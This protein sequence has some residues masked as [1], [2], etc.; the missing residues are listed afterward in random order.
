MDKVYQ[1]SIS[2]KANEML[3]DHA[4]FISGVSETAALRLVKEFREG[5]ESLVRFP[6]RCPWLWDDLLPKHKY[7]KLI[8][9][10]K[11]LALFQVV[12]DWV[13]IE[14]LV[15]CRQNYSWLIA[16]DKK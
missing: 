8:F 6:E 15:D 11:H 4:A 10:E 16:G 7:R 9:S 2:P 12:D 14:Y 1:V 3:V 13:Y 5:A